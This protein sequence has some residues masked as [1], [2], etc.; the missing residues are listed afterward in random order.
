MPA[1]DVLELLR[2]HDP[3][4]GLPPASTT[5][6]ETLRRS[7]VTVPIAEP[8]RRASRPRGRIAL[9]AA[10]LAL[11]L[12]AGGWALQAAIFDTASTVRDDFADVTA[13]IPLPPGAAWQSPSLDGDA[14]YGR[15]AALML[16]LGQASCAWLDYW[17]EGNTSQQAEALTGLRRIRALMPLHEAGAQEEAGGYDAASLRYFDRLIAEAE[18]GESRT[19]EQY[20]AANCS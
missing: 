1:P 11:A 16:A 13:T 9:A 14:L 6:R 3:A 17:N 2:K 12:A 8:R 15:Q 10:V 18:R 4:R 7:I 5:A 19:V 20:L